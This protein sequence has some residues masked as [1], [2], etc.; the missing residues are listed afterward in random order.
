MA[1]D[2]RKIN[3]IGVAHETVKLGNT[4]TVYSSE[5][6]FLK[7]DTRILNK[8]VVIEGIADAVSGSNV[9]ASLL[10]TYG[11]GG[12]KAILKDAPFADLTNAA[13]VAAGAVDLNAYPAPYYYIGLLSDANE[14]ANKVDLYIYFTE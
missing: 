10:G 12:T 5:I 8:Y 9:D 14:T 3:G 2:V 4:T 7:P 11:S 1:W 13:K 6:T